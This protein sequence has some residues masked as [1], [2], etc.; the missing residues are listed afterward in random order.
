MAK[1][2][3]VIQLSFKNE[4]DEYELF[5]F[6]KQ[7]L[8]AAA[9][10]KETMWDL[11]RY[12]E[13]ALTGPFAPVTPRAEQ[14]NVQVGVTPTIAEEAVIEESV[15]NIFDEDAEREEVDF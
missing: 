1:A 15:Y 3:N 11:Y 6:L 2:R 12:K 5:L 10:I 13:V 14:S 8:N 9:F 7:K 4:G